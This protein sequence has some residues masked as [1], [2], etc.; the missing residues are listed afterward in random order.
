MDWLHEFP[1]M[2]RDGLRDMKKA[3][4]LGFREF[5]RAYGEGLEN[6]F[7]PLLLFLVWLEQLLINTPWPVV[8]LAI[9]ALT[10]I[11]ARSW[12]IVVGTTLCFLAIAYL[13]YR[14]V[15]KEDEN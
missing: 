7:E 4:D 10:W 2:E 15:T 6:F 14:L 3:I 5:S 11:G 1:A 13:G 8:I 12:I 9:V